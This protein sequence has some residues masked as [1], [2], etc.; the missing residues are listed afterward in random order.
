MSA[1]QTFSTE[2]SLMWEWDNTKSFD[3][4]TG[5]THTMPSYRVLNFAWGEHWVTLYLIV[6]YRCWR[7][8]HSNTVY[9]SDYNIN[10][11]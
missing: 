3:V 10:A 9:E 7:I 6:L 11:I 2:V 8:H 4:A 5:S 1:Q